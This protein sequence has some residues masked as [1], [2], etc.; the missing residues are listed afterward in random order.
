MKAT[1]LCS[2]YPPSTVEASQGALFDAWP[3]RGHIVKRRFVFGILSRGANRRGETKGPNALFQAPKNQLQ[4]VKD[5]RL[6]L[7]RGVYIGGILEAR[8]SVTFSRVMN[9]PQ[10]QLLAPTKFD[11]RQGPIS[12]ICI[13]LDTA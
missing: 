2:L 7:I 9:P 13:Y 10:I 1:Y 11:H 3:Q 5:A 8:A 4:Q 12:N 6:R